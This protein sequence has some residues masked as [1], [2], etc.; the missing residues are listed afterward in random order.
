MSKEERFENRQWND[1]VRDVKKAYTQFSDFEWKVE[2]DEPKR[3]ARHLS[4]AVDDFN[5][6]VTHIEKAEVGPAQKGGVDDMNHGI[7][8]LS[9]AVTALDSGKVDSAQRHYD[10]AVTSFNKANTILS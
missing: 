9:D 3:A 4:K 1:A 2:I 7:K 10:K 8:E 5:A 6:A